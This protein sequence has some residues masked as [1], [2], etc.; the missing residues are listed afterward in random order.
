MRFGQCN[1]CR[2]RQATWPWR[3]ERML[4]CQSIL[5]ITVVL[6][7]RYL[8]RINNSDVI[9]F[10]SSPLGASWKYQMQ[11][12]YS[13]PDPSKGVQVF[14]LL[15]FHRQVVHRILGNVVRLH[16][17]GLHDLANS[18]DIY[19]ISF[20]STSPHNSNIVFSIRQFQSSM[21]HKS[22]TKPFSRNRML[23]SPWFIFCN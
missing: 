14:L 8:N 16:S 22:V 3:V 7:L 5:F 2:I 20:I 1:H 12:G 6:R 13:P 19:F 10:F 11:P 18:A 21:D 23:A 9:R 4:K 17:F 15:R